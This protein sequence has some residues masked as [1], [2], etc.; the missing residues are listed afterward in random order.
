M[1]W[2]G[3]ERRRFPRAA[4]ACRVVIDSSGKKIEAMTENIGKGGIKII[5][6]EELA[7]SSV[8]G[9]ELEIEKGNPIK[10]EGTIMWVREVR[11]RVL[12]GSSIFNTGI[13]FTTISQDDRNKVK[14]LIEEILNKEESSQ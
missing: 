3:Q 12:N 2:D 8:V 6:P 9:L 13:M 10:C 4:Y 14:V 5:I 11:G 7:H 1:S